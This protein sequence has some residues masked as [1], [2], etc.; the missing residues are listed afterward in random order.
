MSDLAST[1][2]RVIFEVISEEKI[3]FGIYIADLQ[4][5]LKRLDSICESPRLFVNNFFDELVNR[6]DITTEKEI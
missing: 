4:R 2:F 6:V 3:A 5:K 1:S